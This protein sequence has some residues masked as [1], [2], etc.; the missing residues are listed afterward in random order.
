MHATLCD[1]MADIVQNSVEANAT[2]IMLSVSEDEGTV[3][4]VVKDN[5]KG[6]DSG[7]KAK[8][9]DPFYSDGVKHPHRRVGLGLP[10]LFQT[11]EAAGG[12]AEIESE[13]GAGTTIRFYA[14]AD[15]VD[16]PPFG[17]FSTTAAMMLSQMSAGEL[18]I[19]R[20]RN[21]GNYS[22]SRTELDEALGGLQS[23]DS[24]N[25]LKTYIAS[26]EDELRKAG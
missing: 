9:I 1:L 10:F 3:A 8:A 22:L 18:K 15:H 5:G 16:L 11:A 25:L 19:V 24:L 7:T 26:Q 12:R 20:E 2:E 14:Q 21:G 6:M 23:A 13:P 17:G 4:F